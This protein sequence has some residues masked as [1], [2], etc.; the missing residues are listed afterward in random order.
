MSMA[1]AATIIYQ[2]ERWL[3]SGELNF[4]TVSD[5]WR[6]SLVSL[7]DCKALHFDLTHVTSTNSAGLALLVEWIK[8]AKAT[9]KPIQFSH[10]PAQLQ[11]I[12]SAAE[13]QA[14]LI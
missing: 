3:I 8:F 7:N 9:H 10:V 13:V 6:Q 12:A 4:V 5:L 1:E 11:A 2:N 14:L